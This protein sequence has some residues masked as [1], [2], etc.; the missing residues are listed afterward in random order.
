VVCSKIGW[1]DCT[2]RVAK[3]SDELER[4]KNEAVA[5]YF[6]VIPG[7]LLTGGKK[8]RNLQSVQKLPASE[9]IITQKREQ[10]C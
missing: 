6:E 3:V 7:K 9:P 5:E 1:L 8:P 10:E 4:N 2:A